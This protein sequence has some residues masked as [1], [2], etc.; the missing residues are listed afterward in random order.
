MDLALLMSEGRCVSLIYS[1]GIEG[2]LML[3]V[4]LVGL[5]MTLEPMSHC[6]SYGGWEDYEILEC[7]LDINTFLR[8]DYYGWSANIIVLFIYSFYQFRHNLSSLL[9]PE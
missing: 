2:L 7:L 5:F 4:S 3:I 9:N 1:R 6:S 8:D